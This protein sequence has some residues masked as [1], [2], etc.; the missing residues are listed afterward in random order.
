MKQFFCICAMLAAMSLIAKPLTLVKNGKAEAVIVVADQPSAVAM[1]AANEFASRIKDASGAE[2]KI[3]KESAAPKRGV[4]IYIGATK[5]AAAAGMGVDKFLMEAWQIKAVNGNLYFAGGESSSPLFYEPRPGAPRKSTQN[6]WEDNG[7][8]RFTRRG[9]IYA[10]VKF[11]DRELGVR[12][13]WPGEL[14]TVVPERKSIT[15]PENYTLSGKPAFLWRKYR[16]GGDVNAYIRNF[17]KNHPALNILSFTPDALKSYYLNLRNYL[18]IHQEGDSCP[19]PAPASHIDKWSSK[20]VKKNPG[21]FAMR[22]DGKRGYFPGANRLRWCVS[23]PDVEKFYLEKVWDGGEWIGLGE[24]DTRGFCRC[25]A[26]MALDAPQPEGF[27]GYSTTNRYIDLA[28]RLR[29]KAMKRNP[30][31]KV[32]ILMYMDYIMPPTVEKDL[33]WMY[34][35]FV[36]YGSGMACNYP[37]AEKDHKLIMRTWDNWGKTGIMMNYRP[38]YLLT[39]YAIPALDI[40]QSGEMLRH[41]AANGMKGFDYDSLRGN[42]A[43]KGPMLYMHLRL[44]AEP[45]MTIA[46]IMK[47]YYSAFGPAAALV[48]KYFN[49]WIEYT[50]KHALGGGVG[51]MAAHTAAD[52]YTPEVFAVPEKILAEALRVA[53]KSPDK[54]HAERVKFIRLGL[55]HGKLCVE[56]SHLFKANKFTPARQKLNEII[57]FRKNYGKTGFAGLVGLS[58][59]EARGYKTLPA[60]INGEFLHV[61]APGLTAK[62]IDRK[63]FHKLALRPSKWALSLKNGKKSGYVVRKYN[64]G[65]NNHFVKATFTVNAR[66]MRLTNR[67]SISFDDKTYTP[68]AENVSKKSINITKYIKGKQEFY[69]RFDT[70]RKSDKGLSSTEMSLLSWRLDYA[71]AN[72][73]EQI[74]RPKVD[75]SA[76][77]WK[78]FNVQW[79]FRKDIFNKGIPKADMMPGSFDLS[80]WTK[81]PVPAR[82]ETTPVGPYV[83][84]GFYGAKFTIPADWAARTVELLFHGVDEQAWVYINGKLV[85]AHSTESEKVDI[86]VL[87]DEAFI[88]KVKPEDL[89]PGKENVIVVKIHNIKAAGG[90]WK[91]VQFRPVDASAYL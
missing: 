86:G 72:P 11:L 89:R 9:P 12:W 66:P 77:D 33:S 6:A 50:R 20:L 30:N 5:A 79:G 51:F 55:L 4:R 25:K 47:E 24:G 29:A 54:R 2:L 21:M 49:Y 62:K 42:W 57:E 22:E 17:S 23:S 84:Y 75:T 15:V 40:R 16:I 34:G 3:V 74:S 82:F 8:Y 60:F 7:F 64:A 88:I 14:G 68:L 81:V 71:L 27:A 44:G 28:K 69:L 58:S 80:K 63:S 53:E 48:E 76:K 91:K 61:D 13:L 67:V 85:G 37:M 18:A 43:T 52:Y 10:V 56:F 87:W 32:A 45:Q 41:A 65:K 70:A 39:G 73:E 83:G 78:D 35:K 1:F 59:T 36:P 90:I 46:D 19:P 31:V 26:C 38:N